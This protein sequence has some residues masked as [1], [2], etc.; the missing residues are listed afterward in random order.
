MKHGV[1]LNFRDH[2]TWSHPNGAINPH[3]IVKPTLIDIDAN[4]SENGF[5][6][7][8]NYPLE[9]SSSIFEKGVEKVKF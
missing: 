1:M 8:G 4:E 6:Y 9:N 5:P 7:N 2:R 3:G